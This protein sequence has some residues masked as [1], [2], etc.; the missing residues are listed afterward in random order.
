LLL[1]ARV[2]HHNTRD[3]STIAMV[4]HLLI[5]CYLYRGI[6][7]HCN[8]CAHVVPVLLNPSIAHR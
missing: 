1:G 7:P 8:K 6:S 5:G 4:L 3:T 2:W